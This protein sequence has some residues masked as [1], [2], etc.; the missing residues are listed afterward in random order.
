V[1][2]GTYLRE[3]GKENWMGL[4]GLRATTN[5]IYE[6]GKTLHSTTSKRLG[7]LCLLT[8]SQKQIVCD[9][10]SVTQ[11]REQTTAETRAK[12]IGVASD[13]RAARGGQIENIGEVL[14]SP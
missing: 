9:E 12:R 3:L 13:Q 6:G 8:S 4:Y 10:I 7:Q 2:K 1:V 14:S 5:L 11:K